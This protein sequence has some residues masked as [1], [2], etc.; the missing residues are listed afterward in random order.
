MKKNQRSRIFSITFIFLV[1]L[2]LYRGESVGQGLVFL[3]ESEYKKIPLASTAMMGNLPE[4]KDLSEWFPQPGDQ[5][6]QSS[7]VA[8][9]VCYALKSY[10]EA[11]EKRRKPTDYSQIFSPSY[12]YNQIKLSGCGSG[13]YIDRALD[14]I[15]QEGVVP[16]NQ[17][18]YDEFNCLRMPSSSEKNNAKP[19]A[20]AEW[21]TVPL[22]N[23]VDVKSHIASGFPVVIGMM[24]DEGFQALRGGNIYHYSS[25]NEKG[26][27]AMVVVG[28]DDHKGAFKVINSWGTQWGDGGF[29]WISYT[30]FKNRVREAYSAQ[31]I[32]VNDPTTINPVSPVTPNP[33]INPVIDIPAPVPSANIS[34]SLNILNVTHN[35]PVNINGAQYPGMA[36]S[37]P[38]S[39]INARGSSAQIVIRF[40]MPDGKPLQANI[41]EPT[42]RD[43]HGSVAVGSPVLPVLNDPAQT[44]T[45]TFVIP[46]YALNLIP[47][48]GVQSYS[49]FAVATLYINNFEKARSP[50]TNMIVRY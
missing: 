25:G 4:S 34:A 47:T 3:S 36:I 20:I 33:S 15:K 26:G 14:L 40:L 44:G 2:L 10:Q 9:A 22:E 27:H 30:A 6:A 43:I 5:G 21:R 46:Y 1:A 31:D 38:G 49:L 42:F 8:W 13:S 37:V 18:P 23:Q 19:Y 7:C 45:K 17:F 32:V 39:I 50:M 29:G 35:V 24:I 12:I 16:Y 28:Y 11:V 41:Y 48:N